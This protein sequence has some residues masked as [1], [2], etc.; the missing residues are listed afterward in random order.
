MWRY[1]TYPAGHP[2]HVNPHRLSGD[3]PGNHKYIVLSVGFDDAVFSSIYR[4]LPSLARYIVDVRDLLKPPPKG[5]RVKG[6]FP[7]RGVRD[8][9][10]NRPEFEYCRRACQAVLEQHGIVI[11]A[12]S[13]GH[14]RAPTIA[15]CLEGASYTLHVTIRGLPEMVVI[16]LLHTV[17]DIP[18]DLQKCMYEW[19]MSCPN[20]WRLAWQWSATAADDVPY[21]GPNAAI[22]LWSNL[23][24]P[25]GEYTHVTMLSADGEPCDVPVSYLL[26][27]C[28]VDAAC[29]SGRRVL[30]ILCAIVITY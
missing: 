30:T 4:Q 1:Q 5:Q 6:K 17:V 13:S 15:H 22:A 8:Q 29:C 19:I 20:A 25:G 3:W 14:H 26:P 10:E 24:G 18:L 9:V 28:L 11:V 2:L 23:G 16:K 7:L 12:C 27:R 21:P